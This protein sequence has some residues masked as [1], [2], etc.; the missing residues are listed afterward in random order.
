MQKADLLI[1]LGTEELPPRA[2]KKLSDVFCQQIMQG[3]QQAGIEHGDYTPYATPRRLAILVK[4]VAQSQ[5]DQQI[6]R[7]GPHIKAAYDADGNPTKAALGFAHSCGVDFAQISTTET[8]KGTYL[9]YSSVQKGADTAS[10]IGDIIEQ[11]LKQ[12]PIPKR[13]RWGNRDVA[14]VRPAHWL[15]VLHGDQVIPCRI[16]DQDAGNTSQGH[17]FHHPQD[18]T[19]QQAKDYESAL[20]QA[21]VIASFEQRKTSI[22]QK[23]LAAAKQYQAEAIIDADLLDEVTGLVEWPVAVLGEFEEKYLRVPPEVLIKTMQD[24][25][26]YFPLKDT[27]GKLVNA[28][29]TLSNIESKDPQQVKQGNERVVRPRLADAEFFWDSDRKQPLINRL[30]QLKSVV[31]QKQLGTLFDKSQRIAALAKTI[32]KPIH[33]DQQK[34]AQAAQLCKCDL[35]TAMVGEFASL[36]G[37]IGQYY[38]RHD[39]VNDEVARAIFEHYLPRFAGDQLPS[40]TTGQSIALADKLDT[41]CGIFAIGQKPSGMKDPFALRRAALG[42]LRILI[43]CRLDLDLETLIESALYHLPVKAKEN[44]RQEILDY[45]FDRLKHYYQ[46]QGFDARRIAAVLAVKVSNPLDFDRRLRAIDGFMQ[47]EAAKSLAAANK[48]IANLLKKQQHGSSQVDSKHL[49]EEAE[50]ALHQQLHEV[51]QQN[52]ENVAKRDYQALLANLATLHQAVNTF[53]DQVMVMAEDEALR[54][55]RLALLAELSAQF[56][57]VAD[58]SAL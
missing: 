19:I 4:A 28:F 51:I 5:A 23:A 1:E 57:Q 33:G 52:Q 40:T 22:E 6:S 21:F 49:I 50:Q 38:A 2:L 58:I 13:M 3:L 14:F 56:M 36:Q 11:A 18:V 31:F 32:A 12:L 26:K 37:V 30:D 41:L 39:G 43:E 53:F 35:M 24:N 54:N 45:I 27:Q 25:Q 9:Y 15:I 7:K 29:I 44:T 16:L 10:L 20:Q 8:P 34:V 42:I 55:N 17:R 46:E 47:S 48:R